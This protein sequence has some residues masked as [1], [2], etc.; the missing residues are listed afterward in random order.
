MSDD[1]LRFYNSELQ[2]V[3]RLGDQFAQAHP[4]IAS[5]LRFGTEG[6]YD[7]YVGRLVE[8]FAYLNARTRLK[9]EDEFP[10]IAA[11][12][13]DILLPHYQ[14]PIPSSC[15][16]GMTLDSSQA[17]QYEGYEIPRGSIVETD[18]VDGEPCYFQTCYPVTCWPVKIASVE[19][20][21]VPFEAP[22]RPLAAQP[23]GL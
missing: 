8:A 15:V 23:L 13:L 10:E 14:R 18:P 2:Y 19:L 7:P 12:Y 21:G 20:R 11:S 16:V 4:Q 17:E 6:E 1:L 9:L 22:E 5:H 3:R